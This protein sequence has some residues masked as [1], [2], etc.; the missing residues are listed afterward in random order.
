MYNRNIQSKDHLFHAQVRTD[1][2]RDHLN[3][4]IGS[5]NRFGQFQR[6]WQPSMAS[7]IGKINQNRLDNEHHQAFGGGIGNQFNVHTN[8]ATI[9]NNHDS[10]SNIQNTKNLDRMAQRNFDIPQHNAMLAHQNRLT[11]FT[12]NEIGSIDP[13]SKRN[14]DPR[15]KRNIDSRSIA[16][17]SFDQRSF[18]KIREE[19][20][21]NN[22]NRMMQ[23]HLLQD[24]DSRRGNGS[25]WNLK[26]SNI[27][28]AD[29][30]DW[31]R[32]RCSGQD[33]YFTNPQKKE[34]QHIKQN[35]A[36]Q[37]HMFVPGQRQSL[38]NETFYN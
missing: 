28:A 7:G 21:N 26:D 35:F 2:K 37:S 27:Q 29:F 34:D 5:Y 18:E 10:I 20:L 30:T 14:I 13:T 24:S 38:G 12:R 4:K 3:N 1:Q 32:P 36:M 16:S 9:S 15:S 31:V 33:E 23:Y 22:N 25:I 6:Q 19:S 11:G 17:R 8:F